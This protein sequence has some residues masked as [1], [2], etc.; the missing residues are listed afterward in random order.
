MPDR[1]HDA[2]AQLDAIESA[3]RDFSYVAIMRSGG[4]P[5]YSVSMIPRDTHEI[6][7]GFGDTIADAIADARKEHDAVQRERATS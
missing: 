1:A 5:R 3:A 7:L 6:A 4:E 2:Q